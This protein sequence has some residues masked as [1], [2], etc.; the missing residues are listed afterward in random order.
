[1][2]DVPRDVAQSSFLVLDDLL[3]RIVVNQTCPE[4]CKLEDQI[5][6]LWLLT[7]KLFDIVRVVRIFLSCHVLVSVPPELFFNFF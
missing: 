7:T 3:K 1:M 6:K 5:A 2:S 4:S